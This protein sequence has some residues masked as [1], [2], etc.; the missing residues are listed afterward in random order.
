MQTKYIKAKRVVEKANFQLD[1]AY[2]DYGELDDE[3]GGRK[4]PRTR[5][6]KK[7]LEL[8]RKKESELEE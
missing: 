5:G 6:L 3:Q 8:E 7:T 2:G 1:E 4:R